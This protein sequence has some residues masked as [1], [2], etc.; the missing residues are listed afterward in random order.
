MSEPIH[1]FK[2]DLLSVQ[3]A[4]NTAPSVRD[5]IANKAEALALWS[6]HSGGNMEDKH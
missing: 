1:S 6:L 3:C 4:A 2:K 5:D